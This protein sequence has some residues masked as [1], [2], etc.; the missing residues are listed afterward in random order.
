MLIGG[1]ALPARALASQD[2]NSSANLWLTRTW[3]TDEGLPDNNVTGVAQTS[4]GHLWVAT[5]GGL[6]RFDGEHFEEFSP[7]HLP[8]VPNHVVRTM[9]LDR[10]GRLWLVMD[11]GAVVRVGETDAHVFDPTN[12]FVYSRVAAAAED[13]EAGVWFVYGNEVG[14]IRGDKVDRFGAKEGLPAGGI[15]W[16]AMDAQGQ[17]WF[18]CGPHVGIFRAN[19]WQTL[20]TLDSGPLHLA[21]ARSGGVW[22]CTAKRVV[23]YTAGDEPQEIVNLPEHVTVQTMLED[24]TGALWIGTAADGLFR[25]K[26][27]KLERVAVSHPEITALTEDREGNLWVGTAGGGLNLLRPRAM[28]LI[29]TK[30]GL[31]FESVR[32]VCQDADGS[33]WAAL[34]NGSLARGHGNEWNAVSSAEGWPGGDACCVAPVP[35]G[36]GLDWHARPRSAALAVGE[37]STM[38][39]ARRFGQPER[40][41]DVPSCEW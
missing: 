18:A 11:R 32:S 13:D 33:V 1:L 9:Y 16:L 25:L 28:D 30:A 5:L 38:E 22:I 2:T 15:T 27:N 14:R 37:I 19:R 12:G 21:A 40:A 23:K 34:Q 35:G 26:G 20:A 8:N 10:R 31:P 6:M 36:R 41:F 7:T 24:H 29:G 3:Q 17:L 39:P 4:D